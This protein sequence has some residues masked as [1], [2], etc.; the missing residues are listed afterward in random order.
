[1]RIA[2][3]HPHYRHGRA[4]RR[5]RNRRNGVFGAGK[6]HVM[7]SLR[8]VNVQTLAGIQNADPVPCRV[9]GESVA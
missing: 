5:G 2:A 1:M 6:D 4:A 7:L 3:A 9:L 8:Q